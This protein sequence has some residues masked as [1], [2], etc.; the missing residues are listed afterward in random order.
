VKINFNLIRDYPSPCDNKHLVNT[1][2]WKQTSTYLSQQK[3]NQHPCSLPKRVIMKMAEVSKQT[4]KNA[5]LCHEQYQGVN[6][7]AVTK[8][9][10]KPKK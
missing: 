1:S 4:F 10:G 7:Q 2:Q 8:K 3:S 9:F 6:K 5:T